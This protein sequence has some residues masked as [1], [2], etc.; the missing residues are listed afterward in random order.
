MFIEAYKKAL[1]VIVK[2][3]IVL[4]GLSLL[5]GLISVLAV[6]FTLPI[7]G[8]G[9]IVCYVI[10][11]GM[12]KVYIDGL[13]GKEVNSDQIFAGF[14]KGFLRIA[15]GMAWVDLWLLIWCLIPIA[16]PFIAIVKAYSYKF[17]PYILITQPEVKATEAIRISMEM[18]KGKKGQMFLADLCFVGGY[19]VLIL[20][21]SIFGMIPII[22]TLFQLVYAIVVIVFA[23]FSSIFV[24]LYGASFYTSSLTPVQPVSQ[25][26]VEE[27][28]QEEAVVQE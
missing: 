2:K 3:P 15:G 16:G 26:T 24:G 18:T 23:L 17:V 27:V 25:P 20:V 28:V 6:I 21:L 12:A 4:W 9:V 19:Y 14:N 11:C 10:T 5:S 8:L 13:N 7:L 1:S 22:G